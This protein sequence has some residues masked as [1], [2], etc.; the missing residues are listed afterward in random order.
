MSIIFLVTLFL[1][2]NYSVFAQVDTT[3][4][5][6][7]TTITTTLI[8]T[9]PLETEKKEINLSE[10]AKKLCAR[11]DLTEYKENGKAQE[12]PNYEIEFL[13]NGHYNAIEEEE[14]DEG[15]W[16]M[17]EDN[18]K[19]IFDAGTEYQEEWTIL[20]IDAKMIKV[21]FTSEGKRYEYTFGPYVEYK[22]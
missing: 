7:D 21:K 5:G 4:A 16:I 14:Y 12:L 18:S 11:W 10:T 13:I 19:I 17:N 22:P 20:N 6:T 3:I 9:S 1:M 15:T 8:N 2:S